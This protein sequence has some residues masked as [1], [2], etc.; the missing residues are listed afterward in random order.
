MVA[1]KMLRPELASNASIGKSLA[2]EA[3]A[4]SA[5][6]HPGI[7]TLFDFET[8]GAIAF[9]V[10]EFIKGKTL[11]D[12][13]RDRTLSLDETLALFVAIAD[14]VAAAHEA[15]IIHRD[16]KP[17][18]V[19]L[20]EDGRVKVLDFGLAKL[21]QTRD[22]QS[23]LPTA[24]TTPGL[25]VG[26][27][28]YMSPEQ[29]EGDPIDHRTDI[30]AIGTM[31]HEAVTGTHPFKG[32]SPSSTIG[33]I[34]KE[35]PAQW[36]SSNLPS[37]LEK[38][39]RKCLRK[40]RQERYQT[41]RELIVDLEAIRKDPESS[42]MPTPGEGSVSDAEFSLSAATARKLFLL[43]QYGY[44]ALYGAA[45]Y[46]GEAI[47]R[48]LPGQG[49]FAAVIVSA[50]CGIA[51]RLYLLSSV[52]FRHPAAPRQFRRLFPAVLFLDGLWAASPLFLW[53]HIGYLSLGCVAIMAYLPFSQRT[54][55]LS[56]Y[57]GTRESVIQLRHR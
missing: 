36:T 38:I 31:L 28:A 53:P 29:L 11:R 43:A 35:E 3:H 55:M 8:D 24:V 6:N 44:L 42:R 2:T 13:Q 10:Y 33:N 20:T 48:I 51:V 37:Q 41:L 4:A 30:F 21:Q 40:K 50:M 26:T 22:N 14:S 27:V 19:M 16:L 57:P 56:S 45:M 52:G 1:L 9:I 7:A 34:L 23:T 5:L 12:I 17:E 46:Y 39:V 49:V 15:G 32:R 25:L 47:G 54:L 18:N